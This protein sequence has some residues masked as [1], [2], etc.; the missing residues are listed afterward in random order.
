MRFSALA[1]AAA[2]FVSADAATY[3]WSSCD[4]D[5]YDDSRRLVRMREASKAMRELDV[6]QQARVARRRAES[7][8]EAL[9]EEDALTH[10][11]QWQVLRRKVDLMAKAMYD[12]GRGI[13]AELARRIRAVGAGE[14]A[15]GNA[16][17][18]ER[19]LSSTLV[20]QCATAQQPLSH[21]NPA[22]SSTVSHFAKRVRRTGS[23]PTKALIMLQGGPGG[24][25]S[26]FENVAGDMLGELG[27]DWEVVIPDMRGTGLS[28]RLSCP[29]QEQ[30]DSEGGVT[31]SGVDEFVACAETVVNE[32][33]FSTVEA[34]HDIAD[35][36][37][38]IGASR[39]VI[40]GASY[41]TLLADRVAILYPD[42]VDGYI[43][44]GMCPSPADGADGCDGVNTHFEWNAAYN[45]FMRVS[46][47]GDST[48]KSRLGG[49]PVAFAANVANKLDD[50][51]FCDGASRELFQ[52]INIIM[53]GFQSPIFS[54]YLPPVAV[55]F[56]TC[57]VKKINRFL[58]GLSDLFDRLSGGG[59][60][61]YD[62]E[63]QAMSWPLFYNVA[64]S[65]LF[66]ASARNRE[67]LAD[68]IA[69]LVCSTD[70]DTM[71]DQWDGYENWDLYQDQLAGQTQQ[72]TETNVAVIVGTSDGNTPAYLARDYVTRMDTA[73]GFEHTLIEFE[74]V[75]HGVIVNAISTSGNSQCG[76][77]TI[78]KLADNYGSGA[79]DSCA[80]S[81]LAP[82]W[83]DEP[84]YTFSAEYNAILMGSVDAWAD[85]EVDSA[86]TLA[87][88]L[89]A[90]ALVVLAVLL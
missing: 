42:L 58:T 24:D 32:P 15:A 25:G 5:R 20:A 67:D 53:L 13:D 22:L 81:L 2:A 38:Q 90:A 69:T 62:D 56:D 73:V 65:E 52:Q 89:S 41:G 30:E 35:L 1:L 31:V 33:Y 11:E 86:S 44:D 84:T 77:A 55:F 8:N 14:S 18:R 45:E 6:E 76:I 59:D 83:K 40:Y 74:H 75:G 16:T 17:S 7:G 12:A 68:E 39:T 78:A 61:D 66:T 46:C 23:S 21:S 80:N 85:E 79:P 27:S 37:E 71:E 60:P 64:S 87:A 48:C 34:A 10:E 28:S 82:D 3:S 50:A 47:G 70:Q 54:V 57:E 49:D 26:V 9:A 29:E 4:L 72:A 36:V 88:S 19:Q 63:R 43:L 51:S